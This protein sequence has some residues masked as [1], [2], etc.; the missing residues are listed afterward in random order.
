[1]RDRVATFCLE[2][3]RSHLSIFAGAATLLAL[4]G[5]SSGV[6]DTHVSYSAEHEIAADKPARIARDLAAGTWLVEVREQ[7]I[8]VRLS[9]QGGGE[10]H[11]VEDYVPRHGF[12]ALVVSLAG[13]ARL[14]VEV[15]STDHRGM[16]GRTQVSIASWPRK[17]GEPAG[18]RELGFKAYA[19]A[20]EQAALATRDSWG[21]AAERL[22]EATAHFKAAGDDASRAQAQYTLGYLQ[23]LKRDDRLAAIRAAESA[24]EI[25]D[26]LDDPAGYRRATTLRAASELEIA[27]GMSAGT[28]RAEQRALYDAADRRLVEAVSQFAAQR[29]PLDAEAAVNM[30]AVRAA[31]MGDHAQAAELFTQAVEMARANQD[32]G[33]E[34]KSLANLAWIHNQLGFIAEASR[35]YQRLLP[36]IERDRQPEL[37]AAI[38][39]NYGYCLIALGDFDRALD[40]HTDALEMYKQQGQELEQGR[41]LAALGGL[42]FRTGD[43]PRSLDT[44]RT[45]IDL[46]ARI[47]DGIGQASSLR[48]AGNAASA[49][50]LHDVSLEYLRK[51]AE[52][53]LNAHSVARTRV[54]IA[55]ELR[56]LGNLRGA[57]AEIDKALASSNLLARAEALDERGRL[58]LAQKDLRASITDLRAADQQYS[59]L[60]LDFNRI[61][62]NTVLSQALLASRDVPGAIATA[63]EAVA[64]V[65]RIRVKSANPEWRARFLSARYLPYEARIAAEFASGKPDDQGTRWRAFRMAEEVRARS[66]AD[67]LEEKPATGPVVIDERGDAL[68]ARLTALQLRLESRL[69]RADADEAGTSALRREII[70]TRAQIDAHR[71]QHESVAAHETRLTESLQK[72]QAELP[73]D[74]AVLAYFVGD[75]ASHA[76]LLTRRE[77]RH[78]TLGGR[79]EMARI[80]DAL[81]EAQRFGGSG[82][83]SAERLLGGLLDGVSEK[84]LL[85]LPDGPL[86][87]LPFAALPLPRGAANELLVDRFVLGYA[88]SLSL[89]LRRVKEP[90]AVQVRVAVISD[91][92]YAPDDRRLPN[93]NTGPTR[94]ERQRS[95]YNFTRLPY[96]ALEARAVERAFSNV[97]VVQLHGFDATTSRV[98]QLADF[99]LDVL[100]FATHAAARKESPEQSALYLTEYSAEGALLEN[101]RLSVNEITRSGLQ[102]RV[103]VLSGCE[104]GDGGRLRG[105]GV[106]GLT[107][108]FLANGS[109]SVVAALWPIEDATTARFMSEFYTA[110]RASGSA[111]DA[112]RTAQLRTRGSTKAAVWSSFVVRANDFP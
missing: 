104:T 31:Y 15:A 109:R 103:V 35:E 102:A 87:G 46:Q 83:D 43:L 41:E 62:T 74:S 105:E 25:Y 20:G 63:D 37:H 52:L 38:L 18:E 47:N 19:A 90:S 78:A 13:P 60:G 81:I 101:S 79:A 50:E 76:W 7:G 22:N 58:R 24:A 6:D 86:N 9:T 49:L 21:L 48:V 88:P 108:G 3:A 8:D 70:E 23:Y 11:R 53:D 42:Y 64:L 14:E 111:T 66:L 59:G 32:P 10:T 27:A 44:L 69:Q 95:P 68:R 91:P 98:L 107:Y 55:S 82:R 56:A 30:R 5:C 17:Q 61:E 92:V 40:L 84:R 96:S 29:L 45:A 26:D 2:S 34:V 85:V 99:K 65:G 36:L 67:L 77:L 1:M 33:E 75:A 12:Q 71:T 106:L 72:L 110:Y 57:E 39:T 100:H 54:L 51:S 97:E 93:T 94:G 4:A 112:L 16:R 73:R 80:T 89:A 28:Q